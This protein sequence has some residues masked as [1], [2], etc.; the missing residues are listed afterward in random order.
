MDIRGRGLSAGAG[1][2]EDKDEVEAVEAGVNSLLSAPQLPDLGVSAK[3]EFKPGVRFKFTLRCKL[4]LKSSPVA[5][6]RFPR[7]IE[8]LVAFFPAV[9]RLT[10]AEFP[11]R[12]LEGVTLPPRGV[13]RLSKAERDWVDPWLFPGVQKTLKGPEPNELRSVVDA[14]MRV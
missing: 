11:S 6:G 13:L 10:L 9:L 1:V 5:E 3:F 14:V 2:E 12:D 8:F 4:M 7:L